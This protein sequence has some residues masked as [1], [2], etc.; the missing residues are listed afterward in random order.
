MGEI[1]D[2]ILFFLVVKCLF[3]DFFSKHCIDILNVL[4]NI[5]QVNNEDSRITSSEVALMSLQLTWN[6]LNILKALNT[7]N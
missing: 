2:E 5:S 6:I 7:L 4:L 1:T 3:K